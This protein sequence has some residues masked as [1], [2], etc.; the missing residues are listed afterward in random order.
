M[1]GIRQWA[2]DNRQSTLEIRHILLVSTV[3]A[4]ALEEFGVTYLKYRVVG[5]GEGG[6]I[7]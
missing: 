1:Y 7:L 4:A 3:L 2:F 5:G 6:I